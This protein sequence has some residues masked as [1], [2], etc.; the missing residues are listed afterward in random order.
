MNA[1]VI[2]LIPRRSRENLYPGDW[3]V[4]TAGPWVALRAHVF[5]PKAM[6][7]YFSPAE[8]RAIARSLLDFAERAND[9]Q[10]YF[11]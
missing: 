8:A 9:A 2:P 4:S 6:K 1:K 11:I 3:S 5:G 10:G 7:G